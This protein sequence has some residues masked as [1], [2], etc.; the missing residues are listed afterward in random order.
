MPTPSPGPVG[1]AACRTPRLPVHIETARGSDVVDAQDHG[2]ASC[3]RSPV[4]MDRRPQRGSIAQ[5]LLTDEVFIPS[6][7]AS[8]TSSPS[9]PAGERTT[10][11]T[12]GP[13]PPAPSSES[14]STAY[15]GE[16][17]SRG[18]GS[19]ST[20]TVGS[21]SSAA[22]QRAGAVGAPF[23]RPRKSVRT[24]LAGSTKANEEKVTAEKSQARRSRR[25]S[26]KEPSA[27]DLS[28]AL[29]EMQDAV[30]SLY[31]KQPRGASSFRSNS[32][33]GK[34]S[35]SPRMKAKANP[36]KERSRL[37]KAIEAA[38]LERTILSEKNSTLE[39]E[40]VATEC[41]RSTTTVSLDL[42]SVGSKDPSR[43]LSAV[44]VRMPPEQA[45][46]S[47]HPQALQT[48]GCVA[49]CGLTLQL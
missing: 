6:C 21:V 37:R 26:A 10:S 24:R 44:L 1:A 34:G 49:S 33:R 39:D 3:A 41:S 28:R 40:E 19:S 9:K 23:D 48:G 27:A 2:L 20:A 13:G 42:S 43:W 22:A 46:S 18:G 31:A 32:S 8:G 35:S 14:T 16:G 38:E 29:S 36:H 30:S 47:G 7:L 15:G 5:S 4:F 17:S 12:G 25:Q 11:C 45:M